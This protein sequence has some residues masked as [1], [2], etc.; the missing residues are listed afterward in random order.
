[1]FGQR[2]RVL[3][4]LVVLGGSAVGCSSLLGVD[5][6]REARTTAGEDASASTADPAEDDPTPTKDIGAD[7]SAA[8]AASSGG[9]LFTPSNASAFG[10]LPEQGKVVDIP[11]GSMPYA[12]DTD[13]CT[14]PFLGD[15]APVVQPSGP[16]ACV[17]RAESYAIR[18]D[19]VVSGTRAL[20]ILA[21][22]DVR[23]EAEMSVASRG[24]NPA[25]G[26]RAPGVEPA[27]DALTPLVGGGSESGSL[28]GGGGGAIQISA[29]RKVWLTPKGRVQAGGGRGWPAIGQGGAGGQGG[30]I[31][32]EAPEVVV[33]GE[34]LA[35]GGGG[36]GGG[37]TS[38]QIGFAG[39]DATDSGRAPAPGGAS[40]EGEGCTAYGY[41]SGGRGGAGGTKDAAPGVGQPGDSKRCVYSPTVAPGANGGAVGRI[42]VNARRPGDFVTTPSGYTSP[43]PT[44]GTIAK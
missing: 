30:S 26:A 38:T 13:S 31:L 16:A 22:T 24:G 42:R 36:A 32:L 4:A 1:M 21:H 25:P 15:C 37:N 23:L 11:S 14:S 41:T 5:F 18:S 10:A 43:V 40:R 33:E 3:G 29:G 34:L 2:A 8:D 9:A 39:T 6:D 27:T 35:N 17:C 20:V 44:T 7:A 19:F 28:A 12:F